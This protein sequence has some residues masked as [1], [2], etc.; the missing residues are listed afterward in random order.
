MWRNRGLLPAPV[1]VV[2]RVPLWPWPIIKAW[3]DATHR[4]P[5]ELHEVTPDVTREEVTK[6]REVMQAELDTYAEEASRTLESAGVDVVIRKPRA[7]ELKTRRAGGQFASR[8][9]ILDA[10]DGRTNGIGEWDWLYSLSYA[11]QDW[12]ARSHFGPEGSL[13]SPDQV[14]DRMAGPDVDA[15]MAE[16]VRC[17]RVI[18]A[19]SAF[20]RRLTWRRC[21]HLF[22]G[23]RLTYDPHALLGTYADA[24]CYLAELS[25]DD[26]EAEPRE[27]VARLGPS[28]LDMEY[29]EWLAEVTELRDKAE[30]IPD[31]D[32]DDSAV[33]TRLNELWPAVCEGAASMED[34]YVAA[35]GAYLE[36]LAA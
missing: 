7:R 16:W 31:D 9:E 20:R 29:E 12:L 6:A 1:M 28:P 22:S 26:P 21:G 3:A 17:V 5:S 4:L 18:D 8:I 27:L 33:F 19:A 25:D 11:D 23:L 13:L 15:N 10:A 35:V 34:A 2:A 36:Q 32:W 24:A 14:S 30:D